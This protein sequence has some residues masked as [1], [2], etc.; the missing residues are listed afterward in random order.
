LGG[1]GWAEVFDIVSLLR[2][3]VTL[4]LVCGFSEEGILR[5]SRFEVLER[6]GLIERVVSIA[7]N[8]LDPG[9]SI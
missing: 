6:D 7:G 9:N 4:S 2:L 1:I 3:G 8:F 5:M